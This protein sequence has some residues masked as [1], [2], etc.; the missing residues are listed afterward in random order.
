MVVLVFD[1]DANWIYFYCIALHC[2]ALQLEYSTHYHYQIKPK[3]PLISPFFVI[4]HRQ[5]INQRSR[6]VV[7]L[8]CAKLTV[9]PFDKVINIILYYARVI[10]RFS[11][12]DNVA[13]QIG[14]KQQPVFFSVIY[15]PRNGCCKSVIH[16]RVKITSENIH[17]AGIFDADFN[18]I[19][20][21][22]LKN[23][24][25]EEWAYLLNFY[26]ANIYFYFGIF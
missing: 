1:I 11:Y 23:T 13:S 18:F 16:S 3:Q 24:H 2:I 25:S 9:S 12:S 19:H 6:C 15:C 14:I 22:H 20:S 4:H 17:E 21:S 26:R 8:L 5:H 10:C 7:I